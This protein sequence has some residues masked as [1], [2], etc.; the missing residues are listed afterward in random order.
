M[1]IFI[2]LL[3]FLFFVISLFLIFGIFWMWGHHREEL[4][5]KLELGYDTTFKAVR[6]FLMISLIALGLCIY[7][8]MK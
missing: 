4:E 7:Y 6:F 5:S 8:L 2:S 1:E 3:A